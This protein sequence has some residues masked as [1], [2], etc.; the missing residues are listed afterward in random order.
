MMRI[1]KYNCKPL[2]FTA[3]GLLMGAGT[4]RVS[5]DL[6]V[7]DDDWKGSFNDSHRGYL[8]YGKLYF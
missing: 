6:D 5:T 8:L 7:N 4:T 2:A 3:A 1:T